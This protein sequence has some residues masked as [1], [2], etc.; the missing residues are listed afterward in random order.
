MVTVGTSI[1]G[2]HPSPELEY[3]ATTLLEMRFP[4]QPWP[5][6]LLLLEAVA[7]AVVQVEE[8]TEPGRRKEL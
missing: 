7:V 6:G 2:N 4:W 5:I 8:W 3:T 1:S